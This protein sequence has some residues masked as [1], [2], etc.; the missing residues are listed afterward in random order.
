MDNFEGNL[1]TTKW[2]KMCNCSQDTETLDIN[3]LI[4]KKILKKVCKGRATHYLLC[5]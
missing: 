4:V 3:D 5:K 1:T 2:A